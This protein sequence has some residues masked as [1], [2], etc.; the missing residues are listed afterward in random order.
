MAR[1]GWI[2]A[3]LALLLA[4]ACYDSQWGQQKA[5]QQRGAA[6][7]APAA[8]VAEGSEPPPS[9]HNV[10][11]KTQK[12]RVRAL[13]TRSFTAQVVDTPRYLR[14]LFDD[15]NRIT[16]RD[17]EGRG[18]GAGDSRA[19]GRGPRALRDVVPGCRAG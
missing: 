5:A 9:V 7:V 1:T 11:A 12:L 2:F 14:D 19:R 17:R 16:E 13:V 8:L 18:R 3:A 15:C 4:P 6:R 10:A